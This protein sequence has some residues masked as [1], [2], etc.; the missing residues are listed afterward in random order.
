M[1]E[2]A[3][4]THPRTLWDIATL[5]ALGFVSGLPN[6]APPSTPAR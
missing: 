2:S 6:K 3:G 5:V 1:A 4:L